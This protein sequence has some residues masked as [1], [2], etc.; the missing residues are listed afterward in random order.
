MTEE[1][2]DRF[3]ELFT[4]ARNSPKLSRSEKKELAKLWSMADDTMGA[5]EDA[6]DCDECGSGNVEETHHSGID[7]KEQEISVTSYRCLD[8]DWQ[9]SD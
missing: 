2:F 9:W 8:C 4:K 7:S 1:E 5:V 6:V 3:R